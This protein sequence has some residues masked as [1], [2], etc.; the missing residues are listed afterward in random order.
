MDKE[1]ERLIVFLLR[2]A[3]AKTLCVVEDPTAAT[4]S[5]VLKVLKHVF[6]KFKSLTDW[7]SIGPP[8][9]TG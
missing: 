3:V 6:I 2:F 5:Q 4:G 8:C 1:S 9:V 7:P